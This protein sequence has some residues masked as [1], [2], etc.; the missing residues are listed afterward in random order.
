[1]YET[2]DGTVMSAEE[3]QALFQAHTRTAAMIMNATKK[4]RAAVAGQPTS[5]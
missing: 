1:M 3:F 2:P 4:T 5:P